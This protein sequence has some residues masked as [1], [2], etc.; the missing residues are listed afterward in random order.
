[1]TRMRFAGF[2]L[3]L[4]AACGD[5]AMTETTGRV[6][7]AILAP[8]RS[9]SA[10]PEAVT[11]KVNNSFDDFCTGVIVA[12]RVVLTAAH[13]VVFNAGGTWTLAAPFA[14][15]GTQTR[16]FSSAEPLDPGFKSLTRDNFDTQDTYRDIGLLY[17]DTGF[18]GI[19]FPK[20]SMTSYASG[21]S[22]SA[23]GRASVS[24]TAGLVLSA[25][26]TLT[27]PDANSLT[28]YKMEYSTSKIT[29]D[30]DSGGPLFIDGTH[31][32]VGTERVYDDTQDY[33]T[34]LFGTTYSDLLAKIAA[35]GGFA[36]VSPAASTVA[37]KAT[38]TFS[39]T[40]G[41]GGPYTFSLGTNVSGGAITSAGAYTAG[42]VAGT[43]VIVATDAKGLT[44]SA[45]V[46]VTPGIVVAPRFPSAPTMGTITFT[47]SG[48][49]GTGYVWKVA[50]SNSG[51]T[52]DATGHYTAGD[53]KEVTDEVTV[54]DSVNNATTV[55]VPV[56]FALSMRLSS[57]LA[58]RATAQI[59]PS[60]G[61]G[62]GY[63]WALSQNASGG[64]IDANGL[65]TAGP[66]GNVRD[67]ITLTDSTGTQLNGIEIV[68]P[69]VTITPGD[70]AI[71]AGGTLS[72][73][74]TGGAGG[75]FTFSL[76]SAPS[77]GAL[78][79]GSYTAG[80]VGGNV[81][82][83]VTAHDTL[84]NTA[85]AHV[86]V[87]GGP[88]PGVDAGTGAGSASSPDNGG[89]NAGGRAPGW[90]SALGGLAMV[91][92]LRRRRRE[93]GSPPGGTKATRRTGLVSE[94]RASPRT[95]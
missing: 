49:S 55:D 59:V 58:P 3:V 15:G 91:A 7:E 61:S 80:P 24:A 23:V 39:V 28:S 30:G 70:V 29:T 62:T 13:C 93:R 77:G 86:T 73:G 19:A 37:A 60:G 33:W 81:I 35:H 66:T 40:A 9:A 76:D 27:L 41:Q 32:L 45:S 68:G 38:V 1:M 56:G 54:T 10:Y 78:Q 2:G 71:A 6:T 14:S 74:A 5:S 75:D 84:G 90:A 94:R 65:Y 21:Q 63:T 22:V 92:L 64:T 50:K 20:L 25:A 89:C 79:G 42:S 95:G 83:V 12:P 17:P 72:F 57:A 8:Q 85:S 18:N 48:G 31:S 53:K 67:T 47:A 52:I 4:L 44:G 34:E 11:V 88:S 51:G 82:D 43:D 16:T 46:V 26:K 36:I 69:G 87:T